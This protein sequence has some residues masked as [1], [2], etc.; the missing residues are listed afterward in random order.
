MLKK[1]ELNLKFNPKRNFSIISP[2]CNRSNKDGKFINYLDLPIIY[3]YCHSCGKSC[4]PPTLYTDENGFEYTWNE[5]GNHFESHLN[6]KQNTFAIYH[7]KKI[8]SIVIEQKFIG[9]SKIWEHFY[10]QPENNLLQYL[11]EIFCE[12]KVNDVKEVYALATS[13]DGGTMFW[14]INKDLQIQ[15]LKNS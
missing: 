11:R 8:A 12:E 14:N 1:T 10:I 6:I 9:E 15:K 5:K 13:K 7:D 3:G 4:L 2:C